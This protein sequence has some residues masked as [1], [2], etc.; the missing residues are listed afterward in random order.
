MP[1]SYQID[2]AKGLVLTTTTVPMRQR[3]N[4]YACRNAGVQKFTWPLP[5][6]LRVFLK[7]FAVTMMRGRG[8]AW[9]PEANGQGGHRVRWFLSGKCPTGALARA[10][11]APLRFLRYDSGV[12]WQ[13]SIAPEKRLY[14][15][16]RCA[17]G[18]TS[19]LDKPNCMIAFAFH[20]SGTIHHASK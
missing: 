2:E 16:T 17:I 5:V 11:D 20:G 7:D 1:I 12:Q 9:G 15:G 18:T 4:A 6:S 3:Q 8:L 14:P 10:L 19:V 13:K